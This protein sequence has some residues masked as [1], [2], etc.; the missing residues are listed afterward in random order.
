MVP[1][2]YEET[3]RT[4]DTGQNLGE[5]FLLGMNKGRGDIGRGQKKKHL[6]RE[7]GGGTR[8]INRRHCF[9][10]EAGISNV[11]PTRI[12]KQKTQIAQSNGQY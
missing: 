4:G 11:K 12:K 8:G 6:S 1:G 5:Q 7:E 3:D 2:G 9:E 10:K